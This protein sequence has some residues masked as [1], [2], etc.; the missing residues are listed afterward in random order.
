[1]HKKEIARLIHNL[2]TGKATDQDKKILEEFWENALN[3]TTVL[4]EMSADSR[5]KLKNEIFRSIR[6]RLGLE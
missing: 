5:E 4:D 6:A 2:K 1:M 3:N